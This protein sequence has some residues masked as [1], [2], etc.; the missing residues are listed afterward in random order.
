MSNKELDVDPDT[1]EIDIHG[2]EDCGVIGG[3]TVTIKH[4]KRICTECGG[5][6]LTLQES[7]DRILELKSYVRALT[8]DV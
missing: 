5:T 1:G 8:D 6:V 3:E 7:F 2:C 4:G